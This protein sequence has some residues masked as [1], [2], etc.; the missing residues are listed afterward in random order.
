MLALVGSISQLQNLTEPEVTPVS[1]HSRVD[2]A[3]GSIL[4]AIRPVGV[5]LLR[6]SLVPQTGRVLDAKDRLVGAD[7]RLEISAKR[8]VRFV[9]QVLAVFQ[10]RKIQNRV[11]G[12]HELG[13]VF[14]P[15]EEG[16]PPLGLQRVGGGSELGHERDVVLLLELETRAVLGALVGVV[17]VDVVRVY[18]VTA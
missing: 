14:L 17:A 7:I 15:D 10:N 3:A 2:L 8:A 18:A 4:R 13:G 9:A 6:R 5:A 1:S 16:V 11:E 12:R